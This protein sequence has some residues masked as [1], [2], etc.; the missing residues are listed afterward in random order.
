[1]KLYMK[2]YGSPIDNFSICDEDSNTVYTAKRRPRF[3]G[4]SHNVFDANGLI[5]ACI[6]Q[7]VL[8]FLHRYIIEIGGITFTVVKEFGLLKSRYRVK[9]TDWTIQGDFWQHEY[10]IHDGFDTVM[11]LSKHWHTRGDSYELDISDGENTL[12]AICTAI[13][14][15]C[16]CA[17]RTQSRFYH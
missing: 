10:E 15:D 2:Q 1:M 12:L 13:A 4:R 17:D 14:I 5:V 9:Y 6:K 11:H 7:K 16:I 8:S 3:F